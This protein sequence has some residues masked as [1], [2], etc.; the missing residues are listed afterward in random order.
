MTQK[1]KTNKVK[2]QRNFSLVKYPDGKFV[3]L[4]SYQTFALPKPVDKEHAY[5][6]TPSKAEA[7]VSHYGSDYNLEIVDVDV[8][9]D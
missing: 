5:L 8:Y 9:L 3:A 1:K 2:W 7:Y 4:S 6:F